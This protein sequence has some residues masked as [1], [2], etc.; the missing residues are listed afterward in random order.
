MLMQFFTLLL[1]FLCSMT[2]LIPAQVAK[3]AR[4]AEMEDSSKEV[5][6]KQEKQAIHLQQLHKE[7]VTKQ[8]SFTTGFPQ[9]ISASRAAVEKNFG[10]HNQ[11]T[12]FAPI[13]SKN[14][15]ELLV[16]KY[17]ALWG[18]T[19]QEANADLFVEKDFIGTKK[20]LVVGD[21]HGA[22]FSLLDL[23][24]DWKI[25]GRLNDDYTLAPNVHVQ[26]L[27]DYVDRAQG[28]LEVLVALILLKLKNPSQV[29]LGRGNH[30]ERGMNTSFAE[31]LKKKYGE[32]WRSCFNLI[33]SIYNTFPV[34][35]V[36]AGGKSCDPEDLSYFLCYHGM[37][38][39]ELAASLDEILAKKF[40]ATVEP[41]F[42]CN[43]RSKTFVSREVMWGDSCQA[44]DPSNIGAEKP[45]REKVEATGRPRS[46]QKWREAQL[47]PLLKK[48]YTLKGE[49]RAHQHDISCG[50][51]FDSQTIRSL[52][53][54]ASSSLDPQVNRHFA[55]LAGP[56]GG[57]GPYPVEGVKKLLKY[58]H[59]KYRSQN[60]SEHWNSWIDGLGKVP[61]FT[62]SAA[63]DVP[64]ISSIAAVSYLVLTPGA[65]PQ[66]P[67]GIQKI[68][69]ES[70]NDKAGSVSHVFDIQA[71]S[72]PS[73]AAILNAAMRTQAT[74]ALEEQ[75]SASTSATL[76]SQAP[77]EASASSSSA[78]S[79]SAH[80]A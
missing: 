29:T 74:S 50:V 38:D 36:L 58:F 65:T 62:I 9:K 10:D 80:S 77:V 78:T 1:G 32:E 47:E 40:S 31:E 60:G 5:F 7:A 79:S 17:F 37:L 61:Q 45:L 41:L 13:I 42:F 49:V 39:K 14:D 20:T 35:T 11:F 48:G 28:G 25:R 55:K 67:W 8:E 21:L 51:I 44:S 68:S 24:D 66:I 53:I 72:A 2:T 63:Y 30:E 46:N 43:T 33:T 56:Y 16:K 18:T 22:I 70:F 27:G 59:K 69:I 12:G 71:P 3:T 75:A 26:F 64:E 73:A 19:E 4:A 23:F 6:G 52:C 15:L 54:I 34:T 76:F 57:S